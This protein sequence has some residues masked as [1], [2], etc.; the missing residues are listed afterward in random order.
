MSP[1]SLQSKSLYFSDKAYDQLSALLGE[2]DMGQETVPPGLGV[3][4]GRQLNVTWM[5]HDVQPWRVDRVYPDTPRSMDVWIHTSTS[6]PKSY[7]G[8]WHKAQKP[9]ELR[10]LLR[11]LGVM[12]KRVPGGVS[13]I[14]PTPETSAAPAVADPGTDATAPAATASTSQG[15]G[16]DW[17]WA[18][19]GLAAGAAAALLLRPLLIR[20]PETFAPA[21]G[22]R[23]PGPR[24]ELRD[25]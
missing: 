22:R 6:V 15:G 7:N 8:Y 24:Q 17:W 25:M 5:I 10:A 11:K 13:P 16:T 18:L 1:E 9:A 12:G 20:L 19:P 4:A 23:E 2:S 14:F 21:R 3:A